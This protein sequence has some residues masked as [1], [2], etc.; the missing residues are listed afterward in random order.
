[1]KKTYIQPCTVTIE[2]KMRPILTGSITRSGENNLKV[3]IGDDSF[4]EGETINARRNSIW[5]D[6]N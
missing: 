2:L 4:G 3:K 1:M 5:D 6:E